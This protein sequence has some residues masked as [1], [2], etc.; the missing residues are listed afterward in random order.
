MAT[1]V[2]WCQCCRSSAGYEG[3]VQFVRLYKDSLAISFES[4]LI[5]KGRVELYRNGTWN[6]VCNEWN[7]KISEVTCHQFGYEYE[8]FEQVSVDYVYYD[9][10]PNDV[11]IDNTTQY[12]F[13][14]DYPISNRTYSA[15]KGP[16]NLQSHDGRM[17]PHLLDVV[18]TGN[19]SAIQECHI[20]D[21]GSNQESCPLGKRTVVLC[22]L[23]NSH[24]KVMI[25][26][27]M[28]FV[29]LSIVPCCMYMIDKARNR[30]AVT[31]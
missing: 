19:E 8:G 5:I 10:A 21:L 27:L 28:L 2:D 30:S 23:D 17:L 25:C 11:M 26:I 24:M 16:S 1:L 12:E 18:C 4:Y 9:D 29:V 7:S 14:L 15:D 22:L 20:R 31:Y 3:D 6:A 13:T